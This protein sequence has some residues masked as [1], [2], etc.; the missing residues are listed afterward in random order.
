MT[1]ATNNDENNTTESVIGKYIINLPIVPGHN[2]N[3]KKAAKVVAVEAIIGQ[4]IS[5]TP[6]IA[7]CFLVKP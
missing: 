3:G 1:N 4:A 6:S 7:A 2:P 5:P